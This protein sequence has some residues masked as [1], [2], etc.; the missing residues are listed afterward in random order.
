[1][2][3][4]PSTPPAIADDNLT[5]VDEASAEQD[6]FAATAV[7]PDPE[8]DYWFWDYLMGGGPG[9]SFSVQSPGAGKATASAQL[10][11]RL[12]GATTTGMED[13]HHVQVHLN[14]VFVGESTWKGSG[15]HEVSFELSQSLVENGE[16]QVQIRG[17]LDAAPYSILYVDSVMIR[18]HRL[19]HAE[20]D[21]LHWIGDRHS[22]VALSGFSSSDIM[23]FDVT[24]VRHPAIIADPLI[25]A[26]ALDDEHRRLVAPDPDHVYF[27]VGPE[28]VRSPEVMPW[29]W[30]QPRL[31]RSRNRAD[32]LILAP[33]HLIEAAVRLADYRAESGLETMVVDIEH[34]YNEFGKGFPTPHAI[35]DFLVYSH[36]HWRRAPR[37]VAL[38]GTGSFDYRDLLGVGDNLV[39]TLMARATQGIYASDNTLAGV[40]GG[41]AALDIAIGRIPVSNEAES[42]KCVHSS[43]REL[44]HSCRFPTD[45]ISAPPLPRTAGDLRIRFVT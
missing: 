36:E 41:G 28:G 44:A 13:E 26:A 25:G 20:N 30:S 32:Y 45:R 31:R 6:R 19:Y 22:S 9:K 2:A 8:S 38:V 12:Y 10:N 3:Q 7:A 18:F 4:V 15:P 35:R 27:A 37:Y 42:K 24:D 17:I 1:M 5:F 14:G 34:I 16:N 39:P 40:V 29:D 43:H 21:E 11:L 33:A 23:L